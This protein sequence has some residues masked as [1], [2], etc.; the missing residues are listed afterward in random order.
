MK[1]LIVTNL[2]PNA[3][4]PNRATFNFQQFS[5][6]SRLC[7]L[8]VVAPVPYFYKP[9]HRHPEPSREM[10]S[11]FP[12]PK[13]PKSQ[14]DFGGRR[15]EGSPSISA[16][17]SS[18]RPLDS[19]RNDGDV[20]RQIPVHETISGIEVFHPRYLAIPKIFRFTHGPAYFMGIWHTLSS[21]QRSFQYDAILAAWAYPD[22]FGAALAARLL[23]KKFYVKVHGSDINLAH[24]YWGRTTMIRWALGKADRVIA[25][26]RPLKE[27]LVAM[28]IPDEKIVIIPNGVDK[29]RFYPRD[30]V[31][32]RRALGLEAD[33]KFILCV[34]NLA[35]VKGVEYLVRAFKKLLS[36][37]PEPRVSKPK[38]LDAGEESPNLWRFLTAFGMTA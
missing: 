13:P 6:L 10:L 29:A 31:E 34:G 14:S 4:E 16:G 30:K 9:P 19:A 23:K 27:K 35:K 11:A 36:G 15:G 18:L 22:A 37:H 26:S 38:A 3:Q 1:L 17:D 8:K 28:G 5:A 20:H 25:V 32:C 24:K 2:F 33:R 12:G 21:I 7:E